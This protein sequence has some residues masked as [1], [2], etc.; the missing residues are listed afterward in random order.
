MWKVLMDSTKNA[1]WKP[2]LDFGDGISAVVFIWQ[3]AQNNEK[4]KEADSTSHGS[5]WDAFTAGLYNFCNFWKLARP[6]ILVSWA[7]VAW[8]SM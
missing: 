3:K 8:P 4:K 5:T 2:W 7:E 1:A 6:S